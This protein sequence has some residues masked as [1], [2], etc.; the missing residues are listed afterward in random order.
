MRHKFCARMSVRPGQGT[1][2]YLLV[3]GSLVLLCGAMALAANTNKAPAPPPKP[4]PATKPAAPAQ[5]PAPQQQPARPNQTPVQQ[6][7]AF[8]N[9]FHRN[10]VPAQTPGSNVQRFPPSRVQPGTGNPTAYRPN[11]APGGIRAVSPRGITRPMGVPTITRNPGGGSTS[12]FRDGTVLTKNAQGKVTHY[13]NQSSGVEA[14]FNQ[15]GSHITRALQGGG[16][17]DIRTANNQRFIETTR[18]GPN[19][20]ERIVSYG[21][22]RGYVE[23]PIAGRA[24]YVQRTTVYGTR[25]YTTVY[26]SYTYQNVV[27]YRPVPAYVFA[28]AFYGWM[29]ARWSAPVYYA[30][31]AWGWVGQPWYGYYGAAFTPYPTYNSPDQWLTDYVVAANYQQVYQ[32]QQAQQADGSVAPPQPQNLSDDD[33]AL[34]N[35]DIKA[36]ISREQQSS[37]TA[38]E[39]QQAPDAVPEALQDHIFTV[40]AAPVAATMED[41]GSCNLAEGDMLVRKSDTPDPDQSVDV[42]VKIS[43][44]DATHPGLCAAQTRARVRV[45]DL[46]EMYNHKKELLAEGEQKQADLMGKKHGLPK[47]P[48]PQMKEVASGQAQPVDDVTATLNQMVADANQTQQQVSAASGT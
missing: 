8:N 26:R 25:T 14:S 13:G 12:R 6:R 32:D 35:Q 48:K 11:M 42:L 18:P 22:N 24:G 5:R 27:V 38:T 31:T 17:V 9:P 7:P 46:Q 19:G 36:D 16:K 4:A 33:K 44:A 28:P 45:A 47:G 21:Q 3:S 23:R 2:R 10:T 43:H 37:D 20:M 15:N 29:L 41:G 1:G 39:L 34:M 40:Y 30:P